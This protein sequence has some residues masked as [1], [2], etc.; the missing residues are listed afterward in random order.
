VQA[1]RKMREKRVHPRKAKTL[2][3]ERTERRMERYESFMVHWKNVK[4][5]RGKR[6]I[7]A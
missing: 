7:I 4:T 6:R 3:S 2:D 5:A 1:A